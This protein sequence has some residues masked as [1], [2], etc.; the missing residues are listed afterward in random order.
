MSSLT[1]AVDAAL[2]ADRIV[3]TLLIEANLPGG[4]MRLMF[5]IGAIAWGAKVFRDTDDSFGALASIDAIED[6]DDDE[7]PPFTFTMLPPTDAAAAAVCNPLNQ[8]AEVFVWLAALDPATMLLI[9][10]PELLGYFQ[11]DVATLMPDAGSREVEIE[12]VSAF[13]LLLEDDE[14]ARLTD[15]FHQSIWPGEAGCANVT[16]LTEPRYWGMATPRVTGTV[17]TSGSTGADDR[18]VNY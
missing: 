14:G 16:G 18:F 15:A 5:G 4:P 12:C 8:G 17:V 9:P 3:V 11:W 13:D 2:R 6:G 7:A 10:D 1:P